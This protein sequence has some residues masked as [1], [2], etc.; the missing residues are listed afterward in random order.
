MSAWIPYKIGQHYWLSPLPWTH[1]AITPL[2]H[3]I[4]SLMHSN[5]SRHAGCRDF[6]LQGQ[7]SNWIECTFCPSCQSNRF[8]P[9]ES[10]QAFS[11]VRKQFS[12]NAFACLNQRFMRL[13]S[14][15]LISPLAG[16]IYAL[17]RSR[18]LNTHVPSR[19]QSP[20]FE[21]GYRVRLLSARLGD[22]AAHRILQSQCWG[23]ADAVWASA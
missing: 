12:H 7:R 16:I 18:P 1:R 5:L 15:H 23:E 14:S 17:S 21:R 3:R 6:W 2:L 19:C 9:N 11:K 13:V 20:L 4:H 22:D 8:A 10:A